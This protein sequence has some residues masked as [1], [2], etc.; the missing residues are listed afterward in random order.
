MNDEKELAIAPERAELI[1]EALVLYY[2]GKKRTMIDAFSSVIGMSHGTYYSLKKEH[3]DEITDIIRSARVIAADERSDIEIAFSAEQ[4][5]VS[6]E[7]QRRAAEIIGE[8]LPE[9]QRIA[10]A[11]HSTYT[12]TVR[13]IE[14]TI[15]VYPRDQLGAI[16]ILQ[17]LARGGTLPETPTH[18]PMRTGDNI[19]QVNVEPEKQ[20]EILPP[21]LP[22]NTSF[23]L[24]SSADGSNEVIVDGEIIDED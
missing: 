5:D 8:S 9:L 15:A 4:L 11:V 21:A 20:E 2:T 23:L 18:A 17:Q 12:D 19:V 7:V 14:K 13:E 16:T 3:P 22:L 10:M 24:I 1:E 6:I